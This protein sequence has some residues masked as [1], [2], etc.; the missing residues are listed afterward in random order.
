MQSQNGKLPTTFFDTKKIIEYRKQSQTY[1][2]KE[3]LWSWFVLRRISIYFTMVLIK[4]RFTP[5]VVSWMSLIGMLTS[6]LLMMISTPLAFILAFFAYNLGYLLDCVDGEI[7][8]ITKNTSK[9]GY[10]IDLLI[11]AAQLPIF[12]SFLLSF[13]VMTER[14]ILTTG[15]LLM[16]Y[17]LIVA[18]I[19]SLLVPLS[20]QLTKIKENEQD[21][22]NQIRSKSIFFTFLGFF[23]GL[24]GFFATM[25]V[26]VILE[27]LVSWTII[28]PYIILFLFILTA[29]MMAR[30]V[31]TLKT[32]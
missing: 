15:E 20:F 7:A 27:S 1:S 31:L 9:K 18:I 23:L 8:R 32:Y 2:A 11:Q 3:D 30:L 12:I 28:P 22:V 4:L 14:L 5:N 24:P 6:G 16:V 13:L 25:F 26:L 17:L 29:K 10:F 21:P 19:L